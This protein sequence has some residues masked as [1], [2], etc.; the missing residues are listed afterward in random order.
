MHRLA[1]AF[2]AGLILGL[3]I[4]AQ[5]GPSCIWFADDKDV[6]QV[7]TDTNR[8]SQTISLNDTRQLVMNAQNCSVWVA[9]DARVLLQYDGNADLI[10]R[11]DLRNLAK[12]LGNTDQIAIDPYD[13]SLW[14]SDEMQLGHISAT[15]QL[16]VLVKAARPVKQIAV[17]LD[18]SVWALSDQF[19]LHYDSQGNLLSVFFGTS[20]VIATSQYFTIDSLGGLLWLAGERVLVMDALTMALKRRDVITPLLL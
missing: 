4:S 16:L 6:F 7:S 15:G 12:K 11:I 8:I 13:N 19:L 9:P 14:V 2:G 20:G 10:Q 18:E 1:R 5:A 3:S 17:A